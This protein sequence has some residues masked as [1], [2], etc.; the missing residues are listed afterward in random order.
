MKMVYESK[1]ELHRFST[2]DLVQNQCGSN[3]NGKNG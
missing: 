2:K 3:K 1:G